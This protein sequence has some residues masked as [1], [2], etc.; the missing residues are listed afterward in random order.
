M[1]HYAALFYVNTGNSSRHFVLDTVRCTTSKTML[2][3]WL[4]RYNDYPK[5]IVVQAADLIELQ[6][7]IWQVEPIINEDLNGGRITPI[8]T[9][10]SNISYTNQIIS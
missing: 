10:K 6:E 5:V 1:T 4:V 9:S 3:E 7:K 8:Q 2:D